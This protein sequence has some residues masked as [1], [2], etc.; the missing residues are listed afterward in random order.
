MDSTFIRMEFPQFIADQ[1]CSCECGCEYICTFCDVFNKR[2][3]YIQ[4]K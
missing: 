1:Q 3:T 2:I 4:K